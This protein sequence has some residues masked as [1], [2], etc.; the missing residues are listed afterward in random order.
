LLAVI[1]LKRV[2]LRSRRLLRMKRHSLSRQAGSKFHPAASGQ[3]L[4]EG[5]MKLTDEK[6]DTPG[7]DHMPVGSGRSL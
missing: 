7:A 2:T 5:K 3:V 4:A 1:A 6:M